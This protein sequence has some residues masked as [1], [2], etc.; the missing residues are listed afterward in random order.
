MVRI[1]NAVREEARGALM[2]QVVPAQVELPQLLAVD[3]G[4]RL[5]PLGVVPVGDY[6]E[7]FPGCFEAGLE[8]A[9]W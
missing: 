2:S 6:Q 1:S 9:V 5:G 3:P 7:R 4:S 8:L